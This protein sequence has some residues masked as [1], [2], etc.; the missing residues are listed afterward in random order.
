MPRAPTPVKR[1]HETLI[2]TMRDIG[3]HQKW[4]TSPLNLGGVP[5][6]SGG[7]GIPIGGL[8]GQLIQSK[9]A[10]DTTEAEILSP[11]PSGRSLVDNLNTI[12]YRI[13]FLEDTAGSP[14]IVEQ[15]SV[16]VASGVV[17]M[18]FLGDIVVTSPSADR[19][20]VSVTAGGGS[21]LGGVIVVFEDLT[22][23]IPAANDFYVVGQEVASGTA[24]VYVNGLLQKPSYFTETTSGIKLTE[25]LVS[26]D[27][28]LIQYSASGGSVTGLGIYEDGI[29]VGT[30]AENLDFVGA[31]S[32][33]ISGVTAIITISGGAGGGG[34]HTLG[35]ATHSDV[36][37]TSVADNEVLAYDSGGD[38]INQTAAEAG[39]SAVGHSHTESDITDLEHDATKIQGRAISGV[40][41]STGD[42]YRWDGSIWVPSGVAGGG[43]GSDTKQVKVSSNDTTEGYL[44]DKVVAGTNVTV[45]TLNEGANETLSIAST[46]SGAG[47]SVLEVQVFS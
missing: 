25:T 28:L 41:P 36:T 10:Y 21:V 16:Q 15:D 7:S 45:T 33:T 42:A 46:A 32:V 4:F 5:G 18:D 44:E 13:N 43:G 34:P 35:S 8:I 17:Y 9:V 27:E 22:A 2:Q 6:P 31:E 3:S 37:I 26:T 11:P 19:V 20:N 38:W 47:V 1:Y 12:R 23:Q 30:G 24:Q 29:L 14:L 40:A 39:L